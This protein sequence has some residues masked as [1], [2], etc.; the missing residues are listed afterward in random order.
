MGYRASGNCL[1]ALCCCGTGCCE[2]C[3]NRYWAWRCSVLDFPTGLAGRGPGWGAP[4]R[5][6]FQ[7]GRAPCQMNRRCNTR[8]L[9]YAAAV[10]TWVDWTC[11]PAR[12][13]ETSNRGEP[14]VLSPRPDVP[15]APVTPSRSRKTYLPGIARMYNNSPTQGSL[16]FG[17]GEID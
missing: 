11:Q 6:G 4:R 14:G 5:T 16:E 9:R 3:Q 15:S 2:V 1:G 7:P 8:E 13:A 12:G 10:T 17:H